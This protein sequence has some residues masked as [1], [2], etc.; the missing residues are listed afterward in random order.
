MVRRMAE[1]LEYD[2]SLLERLYTKSESEALVKTM[3]DVQYRSPERL[4]RFPSQEFYDGRLRS[5]IIDAQAL[6]VLTHSKF[7]WPHDDGLIPSVFIQC[8]AEEDMG[9]MSKS[10][11]V[12]VELVEHIVS[13]LTSTRQGQEEEHSRQ[14]PSITTLTPYTRQVQNLRQRLPSSVTVS[15]IDSFQGRESDVVIFST[16]RSNAEGDI[17]FLSDRRRLNVMWTRARLA[18]IVVGDRR[19]LSTDQLW[20]RALNACAEVD[21]GFVPPPATE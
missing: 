21:V 3:L 12:Q 20:Q 2:I 16:V 11:A 17:G 1:T 4:N 10:N 7:P 18:L 15:T 19:T 8:S 5:S 14:M 6:H 13:L 9:R